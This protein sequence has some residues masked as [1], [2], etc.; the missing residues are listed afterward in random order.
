MRTLIAT[1]AFFALAAPLPA[2]AQAGPV[3]ETEA[4]TAEIEATLGDPAT[5]AAM[6]EGM[7]AA[8]EAILDVPLAPLAK[9]VARA[10]GEDP[11]AVDPNMTLR[12]TNPGA[13]DVPNRVRERLPEVMGQMA[14]MAGGMGAMIPAMK[15]MA[16][17][18][19]EV[20]AEV[21]ARA[22]VGY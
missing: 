12:S 22:R 2:L 9:A 11:E 10:A 6:A 4:T 18:M 7:A 15:E 21:G 16:A 5:Q 19:V 8:S 20:M 1:A 13:E 3:D 14:G 17:R